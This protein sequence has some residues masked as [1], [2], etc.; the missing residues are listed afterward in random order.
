M[1]GNKRRRTKAQIK[2]EKRQAILKEQEQQD[3]M[4]ELLMLRQQIRDK[5]L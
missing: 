2:E 5:E 1:V 4:E 3:A